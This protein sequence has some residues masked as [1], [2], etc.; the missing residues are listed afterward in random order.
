MKAEFLRA[1]G[2]KSEKQFYDRYPDEESFFDAHPHL[3][4]LQQG[5]ENDFMKYGGIN[6]KKSHEG[7]FTAS[8]ARAGMGVQEYAHHVMANSSDPVQRKRAQFAINAS[9]FKHQQGGQPDYNPEG[10]YRD[11]KNGLDR[12]ITEGIKNNLRLSDEQAFAL[13]NYYKNGNNTATPF[14]KGTAD[15]A[16]KQYLPPYEEGFTYG[17]KASTKKNNGF[18]WNQEKPYNSFSQG[19]Y[20]ALHKKGYM[21]RH[22]QGGDVEGDYENNF[23]N[24]FFQFGGVP[25]YQPGGGTGVIQD[26]LIKR[27]P[28]QWDEFNT[29]RG[30][31][32][33][34]QGTGMTDTKKYKTYADPSLGAPTLSPGG[35]Q[36]IYKPGALTEY[37]YQEPP[38]Q[39]VAS[40]PFIQAASPYKANFNSMSNG[41]PTTYTNSLTGKTVPFSQVQDERSRGATYD[42]F[43]NVNQ[44]AQSAQITQ[45]IHQKMGGEFLKAIVKHA[46]KD[47]MKHGGES[48]P[49]GMTQ[50][51]VLAERNNMFKSYLSNTALHAMALQELS[52]M[53]SLHQEAMA[54]YG[55]VPKAQQGKE[56]PVEQA[57]NLDIAFPNYGNQQ[58]QDNVVN[59]SPDFNMN[60]GA[61]NNT[62]S[63]QGIVSG[64]SPE[65]LN[66]HAS[67][68]PERSQ[69]DLMSNDMQKVGFQNE[70]NKLHP[71]RQ[72]KQPNWLQ[73]NGTALAEGIIGTENLFSSMLNAKN[74]RAYEG[75]MA[76][77]TNAD[78]IFAV[79]TSSNRGDY[80][81]NSG[82]F[83]PNQNAIIQ[84]KQGGQSDEGEYMSE[85]EISA[86]RKKGYIVTYL[87]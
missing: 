61:K 51:D 71:Q 54:R 68:N 64:L 25:K 65:Q 1:A 13:Y 34:M 31:T 24:P 83:K 30:W 21:G 10:N 78:N 39:R 63:G 41:Q 70:Q 4:H 73:R 15:A 5:G 67:V 19:V 81:V 20:D 84:R 22:Q 44:P 33:Q 40:K 79:N 87:D 60:Y 77:K 27:T 7:L 74:T 47:V 9:H 76:Q 45:E 80:E 43:G 82:R 2:V 11:W 69:F 36:Y 85:R 23:D 49:Q 18:L 16:L 46:Y 8:A 53:N 14:A 48:S 86:L 50:D 32:L 57:E 58:T 75:T 66:Q 12:H 17:S 52:D 42:K 62:E 59:L 56:V 26:T 38:Q 35:S 37:N 29:N 28:Q 3:Q 6:I 55:G 72:E